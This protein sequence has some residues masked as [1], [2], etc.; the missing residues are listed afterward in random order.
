MKDITA[1]SFSRLK[2]FESCPLKAYMKYA[3]KKSQEHMDMTAA[4]RGS[5][6]HLAAE[7]FVQ[8]KGEFIKEMSKF[9]DYFAD[10]KIEYEAGDVIG[11][12]RPGEV[13]RVQSKKVALQLVEKPTGLFVDVKK[14][15]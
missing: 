11:S 4:N 3:E 12:A 7:N 1:W 5:M 10:V 13:L 14:L 2:D 15:T 8:G 6:V 9:R